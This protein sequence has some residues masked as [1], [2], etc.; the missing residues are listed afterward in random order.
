MSARGKPV[1][2][3]KYRTYT[4]N[5]GIDCF[6]DWSSSTKHSTIVGTVFWDPDW[7]SARRLYRTRCQCEFNGKLKQSKHH[8]LYQLSIETDIYLHPAFPTPNHWK[9]GKYCRLQ[10]EAWNLKREQTW[11]ATARAPV[12][13]S[14]RKTSSDI[15]AIF[16]WVVGNNNAGGQRWVV[17]TE[18]SSA[19]W[20]DELNNSLEIAEKTSNNRVVRFVI[21]EI[22]AAT[23]PCVKHKR[24][25]LQHKS[26]GVIKPRKIA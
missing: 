16:V 10:S 1:G 19:S 2:V 15:W 11:R 24:L 9:R 3:P 7:F 26:Y 5:I 6:R 20:D 13:R 21:P 23:T 25:R 12:A 4:Q 8:L 18:E 17:A 14:R 22:L